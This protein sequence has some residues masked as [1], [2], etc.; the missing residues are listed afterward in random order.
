MA[1]KP[2]WGKTERVHMDVYAMRPKKDQLVIF[3]ND[4]WF[5]TGFRFDP[6]YIDIESISNSKKS[7]TYPFG[8]M[9]ILDAF[10]N[11]ISDVK[12]L[13]EFKIKYPEYLI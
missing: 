3:E 4:L 13:S 2:P 11:D 1:I 9:T 12:N 6:E 8:Y 7:Y 10:V 5:V